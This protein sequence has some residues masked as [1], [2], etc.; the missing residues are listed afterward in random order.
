MKTLLLFLGLFT[1]PLFL[2]ANYSLDNGK[3]FNHRLDKKVKVDCDARSIEIKGLTHYNWVRFRKFGPG[4]FSDRR[5]NHVRVIGRNSFEFI[6]RRGARVVFHRD[7]VIT[8][9]EH[10]A[11][12]GGS[13]CTSACGANCTIH[14]AH[15]QRRHDGRYGDR[16][17]DRPG[18]GFDSY[19]T[20]EG[21]WASN[22]FDRDVIIETTSEGL[23]AKFIGSNRGWTYYVNDLY[24]KDEFVDDRG[25][26]YVRRSNRELVWYPSQ[27]GSPIILSRL[28]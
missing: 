25:N 1:A 14:R 11:Y 15:G 21:V 24:D 23:R 7:N 10:N 26:R 16:Y 19:A 6:P 3:Y 17:D 5:G 8:R 20:L 27:G 28:R 13:A 4:K 2:S 9:W 18:N 22:K 12:R